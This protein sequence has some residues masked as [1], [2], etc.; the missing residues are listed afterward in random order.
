MMTMTNAAVCEVVW[1]SGLVAWYIIR[2]PFERRAKKV[3]VVTSLYDRRDLILLALAIA[4]LFVVPLVYALTGFPASFDR[5]VI[6]AIAGLGVATLAAALFLFYRSHADLGRNWSISLEI[7]RDHQLITGGV[8]RLIRHPMYSSFFLLAL[9][10]IFLLPNWL[11]G[12]SGL[13]AIFALYG[14]RIR[15]EEQMMLDRFGGAYRHYV[16]H[17]KRLIPWVL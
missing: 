4:A 16:A 10:Q 5:P 9:A 3:S 13:L 14:F 7:R 17:T 1:F 6:P 11:V 8:Y 15:Q 2:Y 12:A